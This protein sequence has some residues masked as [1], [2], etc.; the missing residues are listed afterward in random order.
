MCVCS[1][2]CLYG[3]AQFFLQ[4]VEEVQQIVRKISNN[5]FDPRKWLAIQP[6]NSTATTTVV[7]IYIVNININYSVYILNS[8][9]RNMIGR[10]MK[11]V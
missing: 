8:K 2:F 6:R 4:V 11:L 1:S 5:Y 10:N 9:R 7:Y 3:F